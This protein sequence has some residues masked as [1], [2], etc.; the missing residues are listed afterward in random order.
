MTEKELFI[1]SGAER[2]TWDEIIS[3]VESW[4]Q[5]HPGWRLVLYIGTNDCAKRVSVVSS[6]RGILK[7]ESRADLLYVKRVIDTHTEDKSSEYF[8]V[9]GKEVRY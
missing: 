5:Y 2:L 8:V 4:A 1:K 7:N 3:S 6:V 9:F